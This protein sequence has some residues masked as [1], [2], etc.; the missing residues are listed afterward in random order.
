MS[1]SQLLRLRVNE[2]LEAAVE[3]IFGLVEKTI[4]EY[5]EAAVRSKREIGQLKQQLEQLVLLKPEVILNRT[6]TRLPPPP[7]Q[8]RC[9]KTEDILVL[10]K[11]EIS[12]QPPIKEE[13]TE[14]RIGRDGEAD[15]VHEEDEDPGSEPGVNCERLPSPAAGTAKENISAEW[16]ERGASSSSRQSRSVD[17]FV[18]LEQP[19]RGDKSCR[20]CGKNFRK[21]SFLI[22]HVAKSHKGH[23]AFKCLEC[24]KEFEQRYHV[25]QHT[26]IHTGEKPFSCDYCDKT[27]AQNSSRIVHMRVH[28]GEKPYF[29]NKCGKSF[30]ISSHLRFCRGTQNKSARDF[31][32]AACGRTFH[33]ESNLTVHME[34]H[35]SWKRHM[36]EKL[37]GPE[38]E[39]EN[40]LLRLRVNERLE[41]AI[42]EIFGLV[43]K[44]ITEYEEEAVRSKREIGQLKRQLEQLV[45]LRPEVI[46]TRADTQLV[47]EERPPSLQQHET[48]A[49][50]I[51]VLIQHLGPDMEVDT[52][53]KAEVKREIDHLKQHVE[54]L[55]VLKAEVTSLRADYQLVSE[56]RPPSLQ[57]HET[58]AEEIPVLIQRLGPDM[59]V[60]TCNKAEVKREIDHLKQHVELP[61]VLKAEVTSLRA[62]TQ[63]LCPSQ[64]PDCIVTKEEVKTHD[65]K[66]IREEEE[67]MS[68]SPAV[69][70]DAFNVDEVRDPDSEPAEYCE[71]L[72]SLVAEGDERTKMDRSSSP[73]ESRSA[74]LEQP[75]R[76]D[77]SCR[78]CGEHFSKDS[79]L[80]RHVA[81]S[82][83]GHKAFRCLHCN[84]EFEQRYRMVVHARIH[85]GEK[86]FRCSFCDK[87]FTQTSSRLVHMK[88]MHMRKKLSTNPKKAFTCFECNKEFKRKR[89][90]ILHARV[91]T[92]EKPFSCDFCSKTFAWK[93]L[94]RIHMKQHLSVT[95]AENSSVG[96]LWEHDG[97]KP[98]PCEK[99]GKR[100]TSRGY[101]ARHAERCRGTQNTTNLA[102]QHVAEP[103]TQLPVQK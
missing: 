53:N 8:Q 12:G 19:P 59:E 64:Q 48:K 17:V 15:A 67:E 35:E 101:R 16:N 25:I 58:K 31:R 70:A 99:C 1:G 60:D 21:D 24:K 66:Q 103:F 96:V 81:T 28:T 76:G 4:T 40:P 11:T 45:F 100:F 42:E 9:I 51:P 78:F 87:S 92:G 36:S 49:E 44:T 33:T 94:L 93:C 38:L 74:E 90:L 43:E 73:L 5:E 71:P 61:A 68:I 50:E 82:H 57:Q 79:F 29:C 80:I 23:K 86:P 20:F 47:S 72:S 3:E 98:N 10:E 77:K 97:E 32:C 89:Y 62:D 63:E 13:P 85:T 54:L 88:E 65:V 69:G 55:A 37:Q 91:H 52:C 6:D 34:V 95:T 2:R 75:R 27:F 26:R 83:K 14:R 84:K 7:S 102:A 56:E 22:R 41:A 39:E 30:A 18:G 46:L